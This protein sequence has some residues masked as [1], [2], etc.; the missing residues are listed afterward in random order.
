M[1]NFGGICG[2]KVQEHLV[3][4]Q[5]N[6]HKCIMVAICGSTTK[7]HVVNS[8][9]DFMGIFGGIPGGII[10]GFIRK[11]TSDKQKNYIHWGFSH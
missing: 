6:S 10:N 5:G 8:K 11:K 1:H 4:K 9:E 7:K 3:S 2:S